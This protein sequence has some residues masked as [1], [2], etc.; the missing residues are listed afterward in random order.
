MY[1]ALNTTRTLGRRLGQSL[2]AAVLH[3]LPPNLSSWKVA[4]Y[5]IVF[6]LPGGSF[7]VLGAAYFENRKGRKPASSSTGKPVKRLLT[8]AKHCDV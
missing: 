5:V 2:F 3:L 1:R 4:L 8:C 7:V 6:L